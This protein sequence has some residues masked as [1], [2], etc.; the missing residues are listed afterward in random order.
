VTQPSLAAA[1]ARSPHLSGRKVGDAFV[2]VAV[3][4]RGADLD[5]VLGLNRVAAFVWERLDGE[6]TGAE[7][8]DAVVARFDVE[9]ERAAADYL[10]LVGALVERGAVVPAGGPGAGASL[11]AVRGGG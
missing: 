1:F 11:T 8:V 3:D 10:E 7:V 9:R 4:E 5:S 2:V 6:A